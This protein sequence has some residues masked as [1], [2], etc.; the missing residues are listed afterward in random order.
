MITSLC[1][2]PGGVRNTR[3]TDAAAGCHGRGMH[4][5]TATLEAGLGHIRHSPSGDGTLELIVV[6]PAEGER[7]VLDE[8]YV[9]TSAGVRG[10]RWLDN[11]PRLTHQVT[12][13]NIRAVAL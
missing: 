6:R 4:F 11:R 12:V 8:A 2:G 1:G 9:D 5:D 3:L 10:D 13:M 7:Q